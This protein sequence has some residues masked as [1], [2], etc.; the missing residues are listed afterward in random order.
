V[1]ERS[2]VE[3]EVES[4]H[5]VL[6]IEAWLRPPLSDKYP[7]L[8]SF[9][10]SSAVCNFDATG[11]IA[12][13]DGDGAGGGKWIISGK[14]PEDRFGRLTIGLEFL[15]KH[16]SLYWNEELIFAGLGFKDNSIDGLHGLSIDSAENNSGFV[17]HVT[18]GSDPPDFLQPGSPTATPTVITLPEVTPTP[19]ANPSEVDL[20]ST[21]R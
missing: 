4:N 14:R 2:T 17:D 7:E 20:W 5:E 12:G 6:Y 10:E 9:P 11:G 13:L 18:V 15:G 1:S 21:Y 8:T 19:T 16:W 3:C